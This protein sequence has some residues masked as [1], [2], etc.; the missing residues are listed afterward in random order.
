MTENIT[1]PFKDILK[2]EQRYPKNYYKKSSAF[3]RAHQERLKEHTERIQAKEKI[4]KTQKKKKKPTRP[5]KFC[6]VVIGKKSD[7]WRSIAV[8]PFNSQEQAIFPNSERA[9][10][11]EAKAII[12]E[13]CGHTDVYIIPLRSMLKKK[14]KQ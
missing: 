2:R 7:S 1:K 13:N 11:K 6:A 10:A 4:I 9:K 14:G 5:V 8:D 12:I 3:K